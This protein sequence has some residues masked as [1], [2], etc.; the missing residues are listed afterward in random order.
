MIWNPL[1]IVLFCW[2]AIVAPFKMAF[3]ESVSM[4]WMIIDETINLIIL[5]DIFITFRKAYR[6]KD[7]RLVDDP[8]KITA[9]YVKTWF[10]LDVL[11]VFP[12]HWVLPKA[13]GRESQQY[14]TM[15]QLLRLPKLYK[16][17]RV[18]RVIKMMKKA[19]KNKYIILLQDFLAINTGFMRIINFVSIL[20]LCAHTVGCMWYLQAKIRGLGP[21]TWVFE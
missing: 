6:D 17:I 15:F 8:R 7:D 11:A 13:G 20:F 9:N 19:K 21:G 3:I 5:I 2:T 16:L 10:V 1:L 18:A 14:S 4:Y 12:W